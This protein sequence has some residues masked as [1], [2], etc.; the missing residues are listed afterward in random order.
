MRVHCIG[1]GPGGLYLAI[2]LKKADPTREIVVYERNA[3]NDTFGWG[4]VFSDLTQENLQSADFESHRAI[5][6]SF[7]TWDAIDVHYQGT[8]TRSSG[9]GFCGMSRKKLLLLLQD[10]ARELGVTLHFSHEVTDIEALR[11]C[12][13]LVAADGVRSGVRTRYAENF[14][15]SLDLRPNR[16]TWL[17]TP[18]SF[19]AFTFAFRE[20]EHGLF[21]VHAYQFEAETSTFIVETTEDGWRNAGLGDA[22]EAR[23]IDYCQQLFREELDG[24]P[25]LGNR[26]S[27]IQFATVRNE[28]WSHENMVLLGDAAH[29]AHFSVGS[30]T[31]LAMEDAIALAEAFQTS[32]G[33]PEA[34]RAYETSRRPAVESIQRAAQR[35]L[36]WF[37]DAPN[38]MG[39]PRERLVFSLLTRSLR[40]THENLRVR[41]PAYVAE[42]DRWYAKGQGLSD[43]VPPMFTPFE[44]RGL[45]IENR[46]VVSPMCQYSA[47]HG[48]P[49][50]WHLVHL[51]SRA[52][53]GAG[54]VMTEMT[55]VSAEGRITPGCTGMYSE[56]HRDAWAKIVAFVHERSSAKIG[57]QLGHSGRKGATKLM[58]EGIDE[59]LPEGGWPLLA[60]S[61]MAWAPENPVPRAMDRTDMTRVRD[62]HVRAAKM[63]YAAGFDL[64]ELHM[65]HGYLLSSFLSPLSNVRDDD[66]GGDLTSRARFPLEVFDAVREVWPDRPLS[67][68][69]GATDWVDGAFNEDDAV[70]LAGMLKERG[71]DLIDVSSG[72]TST[73]AKPIYGRAFQTPFADRIRNEVG[74]P[75]IAVGNISTYDD[76][77]TIVLAGRADL[78]ALA[79]AHLADPYFTLHAAREQGYSGVEWPNQYLAGKTLRYLVK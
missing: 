72:Q 2:L 24:K 53:G 23:T 8:V 18:Q 1:G 54:L 27:W 29:T 26:S 46:V 5:T 38:Y 51:G 7:A 31:K 63:G 76:I 62:E 19:E 59:P 43:P 3:P 50:D 17:G 44:V 30:G 11:D 68:R 41:D 25:L 20:N 78:V 61:A 74:I 6:E 65:A 14:R 39:F 48:L 75:T 16:Y 4:V 35:S 33:V 60:P 70:S 58:W 64:L 9:H 77:N 10:R 69:I 36:E 37:E 66:Y 71:A 47:E 79:R 15:P 22:D 21:V 49:N 28:R 52:L 12:D 55:N 57:L 73:D 42:A 40:I 34:L 32:T 45:R 13:L 67:V 56:A